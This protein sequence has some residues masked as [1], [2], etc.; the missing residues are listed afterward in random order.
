M[1]TE[2]VALARVMS[3]LWANFAW[4]GDP[5]VGNPDASCADEALCLMFDSAVKSWGKLIDKW[6]R[7]ASDTHHRLF[8]GSDGV[9]A[10][11]EHYANLAFWK[12]WFATHL[13]AGWTAPA[14]QVPVGGCTGPACAATIG[15]PPSSL[16]DSIYGVPQRGG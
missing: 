2:A 4:S 11:A 12:A 15:S 3:S 7:F 13:Y 1:G 16:V 14:Q 10:V 9:N 8:F 5:N 6:P